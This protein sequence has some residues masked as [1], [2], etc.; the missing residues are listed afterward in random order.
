MSEGW[1]ERFMEGGRE[2]GREKE[3]ERPLDPFHSLLAGVEDIV[4]DE[5][6]EVVLAE[7]IY[8]VLYIYNILYT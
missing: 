7:F 1:R 6:Q 8:K 5:A 4:Q 2:E 3:R